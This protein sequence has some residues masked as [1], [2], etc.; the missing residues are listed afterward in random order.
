MSGNIAGKRKC[1]R[2]K[3]NASSKKK[4][5][6]SS[7][8]D[9]NTVQNESVK[10]ALISSTSNSISENG[11]GN[12]AD[13]FKVYQSVFNQTFDLSAVQILIYYLDG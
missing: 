3:P 11:S 12:T 9:N 7:L 13:N 8:K 4:D 2:I 10:I 6:N 1:R 5:N